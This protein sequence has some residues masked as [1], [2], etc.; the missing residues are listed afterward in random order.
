M[1]R[2]PQLGGALPNS[3]LRFKG[4][5]ALYRKFPFHFLNFPTRNAR[6]RPFWARTTIGR[7]HSGAHGEIATGGR[8]QKNEGDEKYFWPLHRPVRL[9]RKR[10]WWCHSTGGKQ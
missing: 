3:P 5:I 2:L 8:C 10:L 9:G 1:P 6:L 4:I 7:R